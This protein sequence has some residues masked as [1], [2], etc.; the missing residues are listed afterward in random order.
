MAEWSAKKRAITA[1]PFLSITSRGDDVLKASE[2]LS[3]ADWIGP[4]RWE[5]ELNDNG[6]DVF[7]SYDAADT[8]MAID[9]TLAWMKNRRLV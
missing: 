3:R 1:K 2:T 9:M 6:H 5:I 7:L 8:S 4:A